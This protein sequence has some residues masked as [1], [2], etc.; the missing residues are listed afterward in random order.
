MD[1][2]GVQKQHCLKLI[3]YC[4]LCIKW[5]VHGLRTKMDDTAPH[6]PAE[7]KISRYGGGGH[8]AL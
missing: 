2:R 4:Q 6:P 8:L 5:D 1:Q 7:A 3:F